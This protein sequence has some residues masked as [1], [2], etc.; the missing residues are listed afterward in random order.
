MDQLIAYM[1]PAIEKAFTD[2]K[3]GPE[4]MLVSMRPYLNETNITNENVKSFPIIAFGIEVSRSL[5]KLKPNPNPISSS[6]PNPNPPYQYRSLYH[7][8]FLLLA[9]NV[10]LGRYHID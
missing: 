10:F 9:N 7:T 1:P 6:N 8:F 2:P 3:I 5:T 4:Q